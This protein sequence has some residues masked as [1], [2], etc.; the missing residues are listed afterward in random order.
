MISVFVRIMTIAQENVWIVITIL[1]AEQ[2]IWYLSR[3][4][5]VSTIELGDS[6]QTG[7]S[8]HFPMTNL[9]LYFINI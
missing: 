8:E 1:N 4:S 2:A 5:F 9:Q 7:N 3:F 6:E